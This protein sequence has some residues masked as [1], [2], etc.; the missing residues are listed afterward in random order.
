MKGKRRALHGLIGGAGVVAIVAGVFGLIP[1]N[2]ALFLGVA[3]WI[4]G[5]LIV[6]LLTEPGQR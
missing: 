5:T 1:M 4:L 3:I 6:N 2:L